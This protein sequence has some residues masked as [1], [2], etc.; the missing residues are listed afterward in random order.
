MCLAVP[1]KLE[2]VDD[3]TDL[4]RMGIVDFMGTKRSISL[5][6]VPEAKVGDWLLVHVGAA[7]NVID[8]EAA[9][10]ALAAVNMML[11]DEAC[12]IDAK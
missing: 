9:R 8:E 7:L 11:E 12:D 4:F 2:S 6:F 10:D 1:G 3:N 5:A